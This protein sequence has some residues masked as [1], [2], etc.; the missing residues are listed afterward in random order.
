[1]DSKPPL[2]DIVES[3]L[4]VSG[5]PITIERLNNAVPEAAPGEIRQALDDL[6]A[7]YE[8]RCG[9]FCLRQVAGGWQL[10]T[11]PEF[12]PWIRRMH[13][14][15]PSKLSQAALETL[16]IIAYNQPVLRSY[17]EHVRGVDSGGVMKLLLDKGLIRV[18]GRD[19]KPGR[20][21]LYATSKRFL[22]IFDLKDLSELPT[23]KE[24]QEITQAEETRNALANLAQAGGE[25][26]FV[27]DK[28]D[29]A[30]FLGPDEEDDI[31]DS[32]HDIM[33]NSLGPLP[34]DLGPPSPDTPQNDFGDLSLEREYPGPEDRCPQEQDEE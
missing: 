11:R 4:F 22:E 21:M 6:V 10:R 3:L 34:N 5:S 32:T 7:D 28:G 25:D 29:S 12:A 17:V 2:K 20:P 15:Q 23:L 18:L 8:A 13:Q 24:I 16:A 31:P 33:G 9:G 26:S 27:D 1:M 14:S 30:I 19:D